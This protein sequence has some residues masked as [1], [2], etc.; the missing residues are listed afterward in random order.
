MDVRWLVIAPAVTADTAPGP[1]LDTGALTWHALRPDAFTVGGQNRS[2]PKDLGC[3]FAVAVSPD[4]LTFLVEVTDDDLTV[5]DGQ[6]PSQGDSVE[7]YLDLRNDA[8]QG[9]PVYGP[10]VL[11]L[12]ITP[13]ATA[14]GP[15]RWRSMQPLPATVRGLAAGCTRTASGYRARVELPLAAV[16][17]C[18]GTAWQGLGFDVGVNDADFGGPRKS[19]MMWAG[20]PDN[21]LN[22]AYLAGL[23]TSPL[24]P[25]ATRR[26]LR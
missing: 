14:G 4:C 16:K 24:P 10:E 23:Y 5:A 25:G 15:A 6:D 1:G 26:T 7:L 9:K 19:Q 17:A 18:R 22:P 13:P 20:I 21:Y 8:D 12:Q 2:G 3:R 11:A